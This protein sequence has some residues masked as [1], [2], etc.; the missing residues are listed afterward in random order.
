MMRG[1]I[2]IFG[3]LVS[4]PRSS[5][6]FKASDSQG[7]TYCILGSCFITRYVQSYLLIVP[8]KERVDLTLPDGKR[9]SLLSALH[10]H[11]TA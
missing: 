1:I 9:P 5:R 7:T 4:C 2:A 3:L 8:R 11:G 6:L 10:R